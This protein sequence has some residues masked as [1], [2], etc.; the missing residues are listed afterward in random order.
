M[1]QPWCSLLNS[2][3]WTRLIASRFRFGSGSLSF[4]EILSDLNQAVPNHLAHR[5]CRWC[6]RLTRLTLVCEV[7]QYRLVQVRQ[8]LKKSYSRLAARNRLSLSL[9]LSCLFSS[10]FLS[11]PKQRSLSCAILTGSS[12]LKKPLVCF[13]KELE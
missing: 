7:I 5:W 6:I 10:Y 13:E 3:L 11:F 9:P 12:Y 8:N 4:F 1:H 2:E